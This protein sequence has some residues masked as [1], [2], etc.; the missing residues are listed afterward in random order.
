MYGRL[1][2]QSVGWLII[3]VLLL[4]RIP[5]TLAMTYFSPID[6]QWGVTIFHVGTY[7]LTALLIWWERNDLATMHLDSVAVLVII[8]FKPLQTL[9][10]Q[11]L[12]INSPVTFPHTMS[13]LLWMIAFG[14]L[15]ALWLS[16]HLLGKISGGTWVWV[17]SGLVLGIA[18]SA[19]RNLDSFQSNATLSRPSQVSLPAVAASTGMTFLYQ[20]GF[21]SVSEEP[22]FRGFLWGYLRR[23][24]WKEFWIWLMQGAIFVSAHWYFKDAL[25]FNFWVV[26]PLAGLIL[27]LFAWRTRSLAP[28]MMA[29]A[30]YNAGAYLVLLRLLS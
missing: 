23:L 27:G 11:S 8:A 30:A 9:V 14:L 29:H 20:V 10:L 5:F 18:F 3:A 4:L 25:P 6:G 2:H 19:L 1:L 7:L 24:G 22:L 13:I 26:V 12:G 21:A 17:F 28:G 15:A 16:G